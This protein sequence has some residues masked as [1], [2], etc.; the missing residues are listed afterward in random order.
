MNKVIKVLLVLMA[1][2]LSL[3][4]CTTVKDGK[5]GTDGKDG[6]NGANGESAYEI[7]KRNGFEGN[8]YEWINS[9]KGDD[10]ATGKQGPKGEAGAKGDK[11]DRGAKGSDAN[12]VSDVI[13]DEEGNLTVVLNDGT[14][15]ESDGIAK[16]L[17]DKDEKTEKQIEDIRASLEEKA[18]A[19]KLAFAELQ[20]IA[21]GE[22]VAKEQTALDNLKTAQAEIKKIDA[23]QDQKL[24]AQEAIEAAMAAQIEACKEKIQADENIIKELDTKVISLTGDVKSTKDSLE[25]ANEQI[26]KL[27]AEDKRIQAD[28]EECI[29][30]LTV[31]EQ[32]IAANKEAIASA[33]ADMETMQTQIAATAELANKVFDSVNAISDQLTG[34]ETTIEALKADAL[35]TKMSIEALQANVDMQVEALKAAD[36]KNLAE[37]QALEN[38]ITAVNTSMA[39]MKTNLEAEIK[40]GDADINANIDQ[41][42]KSV[43][44]LSSDVKAMSAGIER[45]MADI[46]GLKTQ[47]AD[48]KT[49]LETEL[50]A[51]Q[52]QMEKAYKALQNELD[53]EINALKAADSALGERLDATD[54]KFN[55]FEALLNKFKDDVSASIQELKVALEAQIEE[56]FDNKA[57]KTDVEAIKKNN[58]DLLA[59]ITELS[60]KIDKLGPP[61]KGDII[62]LDIDGDGEYDTEP[63]IASGET[64]GFAPKEAF[65]VLEINGYLAKVVGQYTINGEDNIADCYG[66]EYK[67]FE[68]SINGVLYANSNLDN[69]LENEWYKGSEEVGNSLKNSSIRNAI[70]PNTIY[71]YIYDYYE[72]EPTGEYFVRNDSSNGTQYVTKKD[73]KIEIG[74]RHVYAPDFEDIRECIGDEF[75]P[76][77]IHDVFSIMKQSSVFLRSMCS[78]YDKSDYRINTQSNNIDINDDWEKIKAN[79]VFTIDLTKVNYILKRKK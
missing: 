61:K 27:N 32:T 34:D 25:A 29:N 73:D 65:T 9:L 6:A 31:D 79:P 45:C 57:D 38:S 54:I 74:E 64:W 35:K 77:N 49:E 72:S 62:Y 12:G 10:G 68:D 46:A 30:K 43:D 78:N 75:N 51:V 18:D 66:G 16:L 42:R 14:K 19:K 3:T 4:A 55:D 11:G 5:D 13:V 58:D 70:I 50:A 20:I 22:K 37:M 36:M 59:K 33:K 69:Y 67:E 24:A 48:N 53:E 17:E 26:A 44:A 52:A 56:L 23:E 63:E 1:L 60:D 47:M 15:I 7:A 41:I 8:E 21:L 71:Q 40:A 2:L 76:T 39:Q 28:I